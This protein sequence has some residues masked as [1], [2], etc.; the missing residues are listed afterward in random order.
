MQLV[1]YVDPARGWLRWF[2]VITFC[3]RY[4]DAYRLIRK[5]EGELNLSWRLRGC[6][7]AE[8]RCIADGGADGGT[9]SGW[10]EEWVVVIEDVE[11]LR[12]ELKVEALRDM[13]KFEKREVDV[14]SSGT[15]NGV[16]IDV[17]ERALGGIGEGAGIEIGT[18]H[19]GFA[20]RIAHIIRA[21][22]TANVAT[23]IRNIGEVDGVRSGV[24][25]AGRECDDT[26]NL[27]VADSRIQSF[28]GAA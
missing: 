9:C 1:S 25:V 14:L 11:E 21:L 12:T 15:G 7:E 18:C 16:A 26:T 24:P 2:V 5:L 20:V 4:C 17:A 10:R 22:R 23:A 27:P 6:E 28:A 8:A 13:E 19:A 3:R